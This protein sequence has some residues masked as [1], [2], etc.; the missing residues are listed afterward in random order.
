MFFFFKYLFISSFY[1]QKISFVYFIK[2]KSRNISTNNI[3]MWNFKN[4]SKI[5]REKDTLYKMMTT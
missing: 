1:F 5:I 3:G 4:T 2:I